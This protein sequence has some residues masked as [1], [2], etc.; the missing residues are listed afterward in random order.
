METRP[1][2]DLLGCLS[3]H[4]VSFCLTRNSVAA[5][6]GSA[7]VSRRLTHP[8]LYKATFPKP[9]EDIQKLPWV[10]GHTIAGGKVR[11]DSR[12]EWIHKHEVMRAHK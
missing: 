2:I 9:F 5:N 8:E 6:D 4:S 1:Y 3:G 12:I 10:E 7:D 11:L